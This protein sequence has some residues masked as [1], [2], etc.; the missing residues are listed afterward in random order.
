LRKL[1]AVIEYELGG[2]VMSERMR[3]FVWTLDAVFSVQQATRSVP[4][5]DRIWGAGALMWRLFRE[6]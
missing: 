5:S 4:D 2:L 6:V 1:D 3:G